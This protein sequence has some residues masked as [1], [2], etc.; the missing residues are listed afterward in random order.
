M[1]I[2]DLKTGNMKLEHRAARQA[3]TVTP[4]LQKLINSR[5]KKFKSNIVANEW[6]KL[7][8]QIK[9]D[10]MSVSIDDKP[11]GE[12]TS[13]GIG[14]PTKSRLRLAVNKTAWVDDVKI[15]SGD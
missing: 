9:G 6:H 12:F 4:E 14:H 5:K 13:A 15:V 1:E 8:V 3:K 10:T 11:I 2:L 7:T